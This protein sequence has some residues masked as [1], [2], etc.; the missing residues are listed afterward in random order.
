V[1]GLEQL[2]RIKVA[3]DVLLRYELEQIERLE[4]IERLTKKILRIQILRI[5]EG[6]SAVAVSAKGELDM[7]TNATKITFTEFDANGKIVPI[8]GP[9]TFASDNT[10]AATV[11][12]SQQTV[13]PDGS[14]SCPVVSLTAGPGG[15]ANITGADPANKLVAGDTDTVV[16]A[17][18]VAVKATAV[19][20]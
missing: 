19:L 13:N 16:G 9:I 3:L 5:L 12:S 14:V 4:R 10:A 11:D 7:A 17:A 6:P 8:T 1:F 20:S 15:V 18:P 2:E